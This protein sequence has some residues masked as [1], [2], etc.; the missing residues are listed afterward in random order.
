M[1]KLRDQQRSANLVVHG[2]PNWRALRDHLKEEWLPRLAIVDLDNPTTATLPGLVGAILHACGFAVDVPNGNGS[3]A[4]LDA[5]KSTPGQLLLAFTHFDN[6]RNRKKSYGS[7]I[8]FALR[9]IITDLRKLV[10]LVESRAP[11]KELLPM[12]H[13]LSGLH[14]DLVELRE[15]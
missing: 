9:Y 12:Y 1:R 3:V 10:L 11:D 14:L 8:F 13:P 2:L 6:I 15:L 7:D 5:L 4:A